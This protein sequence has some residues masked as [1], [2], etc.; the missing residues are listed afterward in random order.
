MSAD[1]VTRAEDIAEQVLFPAALDTD[2]SDLL[3]SA[4]LDAIAKGGGTAPAFIVDTNQ[5]V[6]QQF[7]VL[8]VV[9]RNATDPEILLVLLPGE[10]RRRRHHE[11]HRVDVER[12]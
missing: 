5:N 3:P 11:R 7:E 2:R 10:V 9:G 1:P 4:N 6:V 8:E 12:G